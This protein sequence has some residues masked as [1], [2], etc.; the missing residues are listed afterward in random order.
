[1]REPEHYRSTETSGHVYEFFG[2]LAITFLILGLVALV[3]VGF[4]YADEWRG[5]LPDLANG[6]RR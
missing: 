1:M 4:A 5:L 3:V 2:L 6:A